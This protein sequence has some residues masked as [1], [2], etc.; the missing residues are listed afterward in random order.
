[1]PLLISFVLL[2]CVYMLCRHSLVSLKRSRSDLKENREDRKVSIAS[3]LA[4]THSA[5]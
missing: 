5:T 3:A 2:M 4:T 1:M